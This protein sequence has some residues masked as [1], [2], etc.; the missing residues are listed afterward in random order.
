MKARSAKYLRTGEIEIVET[1]VGDPQPGEIQVQGSACGIC[2]W[3]IATCRMGAEM[4]AP[5]PPGH[6]GISYVRKIGVGVTGF[7][8]GDRVACGGF[9]TFTNCPAAGVQKIPD[10]ALPDELWLVEPVSCVVTGLDTCHVRVGD[11]VAVIGCGF[12][13]L[14]ALQLLGRSYAGQV[15][16]L[17]VVAS[18]LE[19]AR[20]FGIRETH[21]L[22]RC[23]TEEL[24]AE[25]KARGID[26]VMDTSGS[27]HGLDF[28]TR[29]V[30]Q[31]G[32]INLFG[33]I[34]GKTASFNPSA[35]HIGGFTVVNSSPSARLR[36]PFPAAVSLIQAGMVN[37]KPL[38]THVVSLDEYPRLMKQ[39]L[40]GDS[41]Y[42]KGVVKIKG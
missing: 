22:S 9:Q 42:I 16:G 2:S 24:A 7:K 25:L 39:I 19:L 23:K 28:A 38:V 30:R 36:N 1:E 13:G 12:M 14:L 10:T 3:D 33:W 21:D 5:A 41:S 35:W 34:K 27:Q 40:Q 15:I 37:T 31:A 11:K 29:I 4:V 32:Q 20:N 17:D 26:I 18:R 6:E 8:E